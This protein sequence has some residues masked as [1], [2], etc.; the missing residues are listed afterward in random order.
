MQTRYRQD[1]AKPGSPEHF[2]IIRGEI[3]ALTGQERGRQGAIT[4]F[5]LLRHPLRNPRP[6]PGDPAG[7]AVLAQFIA[8]PERGDGIAGR[9]DAAKIEEETRIKP[10][11]HRSPSRRLQYRFQGDTVTGPEVAGLGQHPDAYRLRPV[12]QPDQ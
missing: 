3:T 8:R 11:R 7:P 10:A 6:Q 1:V 9:S 5:N 12:G 4:A 2:L